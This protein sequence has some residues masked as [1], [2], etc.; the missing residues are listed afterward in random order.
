MERK[1]IYI[2]FLLCLFGCTKAK[3]QD[4]LSQISN[5]S[6][7]GKKVVTELFIKKE[8]RIPKKAIIYSAVLP[9]AGQVYNRQYYKVHLVYA[10]LG[11]MLYAID[12]NKGQFE[13]FDEAYR[14]RLMGEPTEFPDTVP[15][16]ALRNNRDQYRKNM[17]L[18]YIGI[19]AVYLLN[20]ADA[21]VSAHLSSFQVD[22]SLTFFPAPAFSTTALGAPIHGMGLYLRF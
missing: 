14:A 15:D 8:E 1:I 13:R 5:T 11:G 16:V 18:S 6:H 3:A 17:E 22:D 2:I 12:F 19:A 7:L 10:G 20:V 21:F 9:G 4:S